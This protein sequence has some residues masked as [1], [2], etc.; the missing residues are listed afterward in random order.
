MDF[1]LGTLVRWCTQ[2]AL[3]DFS[4][5]AHSTG[6]SA[7]KSAPARVRV[8][9]RA[10]PAAL[11]VRTFCVTLQ[12]KAPYRARRIRSPRNAHAHNKTQREKPC[13][14]ARQ[15]FLGPTGTCSATA[16]KADCQGIAGQRVAGRRR[17]RARSNGTKPYLSAC[18]VHDGAGG[19]PAE[20]GG[21]NC[22][23]GGTAG[24]RARGGQQRV[25]RRGVGGWG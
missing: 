22:A 9:Q 23:L 18:G 24:G 15:L 3:V 7:H 5:P 16:P 17:S 11:M 20:V 1:S 25:A 12:C 2:T 13:I 14:E 4:A 8:R 10:N 19:A 21:D 6:A